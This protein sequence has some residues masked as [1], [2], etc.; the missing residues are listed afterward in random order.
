KRRFA[1]DSQIVGRTISLSGDPYTIIG[2]V[3][4]SAGVMELG[5][6]LTDVYVPFQLDPDT[7]DVGHRFAVVARLKPGVTMEQARQQ[8]RIS[9]DEFRSKF[10]KEL[11]PK[12]SFTVKPYKEFI[13]DGEDASDQFVLIAAVNMVLLIACTNVANLLLVRAANRRRE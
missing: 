12:D 13:F 10:P 11:G 5:S 6:A 9:A 2:V 4:D 8:L 1:N 3:A 7:D